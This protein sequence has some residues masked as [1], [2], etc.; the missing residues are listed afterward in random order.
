MPCILFACPADKE[1]AYLKRMN[2]KDFDRHIS[3]QLNFSMIQV[4]P[5]SP[6]YAFTHPIPYLTPVYSIQ[7]CPFSPFYAFT[8][9]HPIPYLTPASSIQV[10]HHAAS[11]EPLHRPLCNPFPRPYLQGGPVRVPKQV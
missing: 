7:V 6:F 3:G 8:P 10:P 5:F 9:L 11:F 2:W 1:M 4:C